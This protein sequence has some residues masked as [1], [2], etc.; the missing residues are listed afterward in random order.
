[1]LVRLMETCVLMRLLE[2]LHLFPHFF[3]KKNLETLIHFYLLNHEAFV[4]VFLLL[5]LLVC[6]SSMHYCSMYFVF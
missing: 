6:F 4:L 3:I 5:G 2:E 1:M